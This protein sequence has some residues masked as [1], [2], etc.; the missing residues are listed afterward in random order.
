MAQFSY[1]A[2]K[3]PKEMSTGVIEA[4]TIADAV[5]RLTNAGHVPLEVKPHKQQAINLSALNL[6]VSTY[7]CASSGIVTY[8]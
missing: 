1:K 5:T 3:G 4:D 8:L 6:S 7:T 2:K